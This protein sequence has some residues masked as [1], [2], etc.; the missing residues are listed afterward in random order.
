MYKSSVQELTNSTPDC[1]KNWLKWLKIIIYKLQLSQSPSVQKKITGHDFC[2]E[3]LK[4][5]EDYKTRSWSV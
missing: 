5:C 1:L 3:M 2:T 4:Q